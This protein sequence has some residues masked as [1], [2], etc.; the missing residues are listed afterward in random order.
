M[1]ESQSHRSDSVRSHSNDAVY[2]SRQFK[3]KTWDD[4]MYLRYYSS[5]SSLTSDHLT[6]PRGHIDPI[7]A[8]DEQLHQWRLLVKFTDAWVHI[9]YPEYL[10]V[11]WLSFSLSLYTYSTYPYRTALYKDFVDYASCLCMYVC[12]S[13]ANLLS[14]VHDKSLQGR[15]TKK[16]RPTAL[17]K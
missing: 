11:T 7:E 4:I 5:S 6:I 13:H 15:W 2:R 17:V 9:N 1:R 12:M 8:A 14:G 3:Q 10:D 16:C